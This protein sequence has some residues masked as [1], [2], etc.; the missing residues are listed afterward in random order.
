[1]KKTIF[2]LATAGAAFAALPAQAAVVDFEDQ[3]AFR[4]DYGSGASGGFKYT[5][6]FYFCYYSVA[7]PADFPTRPTSTVMASGFSDTHMKALDGLPFTFDSVDLGFGPYADPDGSDTTLVTAFL[8]DNTTVSRV[9]TVTRDFQTF[10]FGWTNVASLQ[11]GQLS[12]NGYLAFDNL[13]YN[14]GPVG[15]PEPASWAMMLAGFGLVGMA[16]RRRE[17]GVAAAA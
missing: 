10:T 16:M 7:N 9:L 13:V 1:M 4:C 14:A 15:V 17:T 3:A 8:A 5:N 6:N 12:N 2:A 11:F